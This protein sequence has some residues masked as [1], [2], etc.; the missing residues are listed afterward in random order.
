MPTDSVLLV[1]PD[2]PV[3]AADPALDAVHVTAAETVG[4]ACAYLAG[5]A[6][7][8]AFILPGAGPTDGLA[9]LRD[10]LGLSL[11]I[12]TVATLDDV[13]ARITE[14]GAEVALDDATRATLNGLK[15]ELARVAHALNNPLAVI[16]GNTQLGLEIANALGTDESIVESFQ[17]IAEAAGDLEA[18]FTEVSG[19]RARIDRLLGLA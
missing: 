13:R 14:G 18:L 10:V 15:G 8:V 7:D 6:F 2:A 3:W 5:T 17:N 19:L 11:P 9:A 4:E 12:E 1:G 16:V